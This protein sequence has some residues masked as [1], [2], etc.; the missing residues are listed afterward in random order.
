MVYENFIPNVNTYNQYYA[1]QAGGYTP[2]VGKDRQR[3]YGGIV[4]V[5]NATIGHG[6][7]GMLARLVSRMIVKPVLRSG[8]RKFAT[9]A[10]KAG[11]KKLLSRTARKALSS[12]VKTAVKK[13]AKKALK[14]GAQEAL[15]TGLDVLKDVVSKRRK[16]GE[17]VKFRGQEKLDKLFNQ[18]NTKPTVKKRKQ[19][20]KHIAVKRTRKRRDIFQEKDI[21]Q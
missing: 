15:E 16:L 9:S 19:K 10:A 2:F 4:N 3:G 14:R 6:L 7:G 17:S 13:T 1:D 5:G 8:V 12:G 20:S 11:A 18:T 21:F